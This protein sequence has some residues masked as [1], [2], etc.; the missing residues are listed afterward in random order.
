MAWRHAAW[1]CKLCV[2]EPD[3][4]LVAAQ[5][6]G[7][8]LCRVAARARRGQGGGE[9]KRCEIPYRA[10]VNYVTSLLP[11]E[12]RDHCDPFSGTTPQATKNL[13]TAFDF[14]RRARYDACVQVFDRPRGPRVGS[15]NTVFPSLWANLDAR[16]RLSAIDL[17]GKPLSLRPQL[18]YPCRLAHAPCRRRP[19]IF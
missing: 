8:A 5:S 4:G 15:K 10:G 6:P 11:E 7:T 1:R 19:K 2:R 16:N 17:L 14:S 13:S 3:S 18:A 12:P 9:G